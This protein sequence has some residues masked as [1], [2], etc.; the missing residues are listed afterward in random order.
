M[1]VGLHRL[2]SRVRIVLGWAD[3]LSS[4]RSIRF[5]RFIRGRFYYGARRWIGHWVGPRPSMP[6]WAPLAMGLWMGCAWG[7]GERIEEARRLCV[8]SV[9]I[10]SRLRVFLL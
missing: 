3:G 6:E 4:A 1:S 9:R 5:I 2:G 10:A 7:E 8:F